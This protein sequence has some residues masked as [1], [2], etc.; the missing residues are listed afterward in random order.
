[1]N[2]ITVKNF[3][4]EEK[5]TL[6]LKLVYGKEGFSNI[7]EHA[8]VNRVGLFL[9]GYFDY[10]PYERIQILG[11]AEI[12]YLNSLES[13]KREE[14]LKKLFDYKIPCLI[15]AHDMKIPSEIKKIENAK[16]I[17]IFKTK[18]STFRIINALT[19]YLEEK[20]AFQI[21][22]P[23][24]VLEV[25]GIGI[26]LLGKAGVGKS[27]CAISL[28]E[29]KHRL[30]SDDAVVLKK[31]PNGVLLGCSS[32]V[33]KHCMELRGLGIVDIKELYGISAVK[34]KVSIELVISFKEWNIEREYD[35]IGLQE[36][37]IT[38]LGIKIPKVVIPIKPGRN[39][40]SLVEV[41]VM[42]H[43]LKSMGIYS[44]REINK[45]LS[46]ILRKKTEK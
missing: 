38:I 43:R 40:A 28:I 46:D 9:S 17:P 13:K 26:L 8:E 14:I 6:Q 25:Y 1:M 32:D 2:K 19:I 5:K 24:S 41:A 36:K 45:N 42:N 33:V 12:S 11:K 16:K 31:L 4:E 44:A 34:N 30:I 3:Y 7:V 37:D 21:T 20:I 10:F 35:R 29:R 39:L 23:G 22:M 27:E 15:I 18:L